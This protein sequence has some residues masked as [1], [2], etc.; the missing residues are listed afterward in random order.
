MSK[1]TVIIIGLAIVLACAGY[2]IYRLMA[3]RQHGASSEKSVA[4]DAKN[5]TYIVEGENVTL[6]GGRAEE[7]I[8][9]SASKIITQYFGNEAKA[10]FNG[11]GKDD[12][13]FILTQ[14]GGGSGTFFYVAVALSKGSGTIGTNA[15]FLGDR[16]APQTTEFR[17]GEIIVNYAD[18]RPGDSMTTRPSVGVSRYFK[19]IDG[20]LVEV[21][22]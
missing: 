10:D 5:A 18:R 6:T 2:S 11:D 7:I 17:N 21:Q 4:V 1:K 9:G 15:I 12:V 16:I 3:V 8:P 13:A 19:V 20:K 14:D 22:K